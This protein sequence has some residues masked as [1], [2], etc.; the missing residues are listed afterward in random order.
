MCY[1]PRSLL[2]V[3]RNLAGLLLV[4][5]LLTLPAAWQDAPSSNT[6]PPAH[7]PAT[8][9]SVLITALYYDGY[10]S[11]D[12]DEA[13]QLTN[14]S[15]DPINMQGWTVRDNSDAVVFP[16]ST[17]SPG[18]SIW[19]T[20]SRID[21]LDSFGF[22]P[23]WVMD[24][25]DPLVPALG[26]EPL[27]FAN[28]GD[29]ITLWDHAG[30]LVDAM[31]YKAGDSRIDGWNG[32]AVQPY[33]PSSTFAQTGQILYRK[34]DERTGQP[35][36]DSDVA[37]D[38]AQDPYDPIHGRRVRYPGWDVEAFFHTT[39]ITATATLTVAVGPD[40][41]FQTLISQLEAAQDSIQFHGYTLEH[42]LIAQALVE[43]AQAGVDVTLLLEDGPAGGIT[44][45]GMWAAGEIEQAGGQVYLMVNR[46]SEG[47][48]DR[49]R[50]HHLK[51]FIIDGRLAMVGSENPGLGGMPSDDLSDGTAGHRG[52][53]LLTDA[54][55]VVAA[56]Q[57]IFNVDL[58]PA[59]HRD[60][61]RWP[62]GDPDYAPPEWYAPED[63][64]G[65]DVYPVYWPQPLTIT[66]TFPIEIISAP[67][68]SLNAQESVLGLVN[69]AAAGDTLYIEQLQE[70]PYWGPIDGSPATDANARLEAYIEAA[71]R[72]TRVRILLDGYF[73][74]AASPRSNSAAVSY[75]NQ[76]ARDE[77]LDLQA[78]RG[79]PTGLGIHNKMVLAQIDGAGYVHV[80]SLNG[81]EAANKINRE[82][83]LQVQSDAAYAYLAGVF[84]LDWTLSKPGIFLPLVARD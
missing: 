7:R 73:D 40:H 56:L 41:L 9:S 18:A 60:I 19:V 63:V 10:A 47:I 6:S 80:G 39:Q 28:S 44:W 2:I 4:A 8:S 15:S 38:W 71:R 67:E 16:E 30:Q 83:A 14:V 74:D 84:E 58:D 32:A 65:G 53:Y 24:P 51:V 75:V 12:A 5:G 21:F 13:F 27:R 45:A 37:A 62:L 33:A 77:G 3:A 34:P 54:A 78:L 20:R 26:G 55:E 72:G 82:V 68:N 79:N 42:P 29:Q 81:S 49:Y 43:R 11:N 17:L 23:D 25:G 48:Y 69:R 22:A 61:V 50:S 66:G 57:T 64:S 59:H 70:A 76:I 52:A 1:K 35:V 36:P 31:V 46:A